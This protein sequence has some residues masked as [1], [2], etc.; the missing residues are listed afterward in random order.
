MHL[1][2]RTIRIAHATDKIMHQTTRLGQAQEVDFRYKNAQG[3]AFDLFGFN[4]N[5]SIIVTIFQR[6]SYK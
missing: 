2:F 4:V 6:I 3:N 5:Q 1:T